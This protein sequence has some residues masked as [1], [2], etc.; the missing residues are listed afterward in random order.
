MAE[1][2][3][4]QPE[5]QDDGIANEYGYFFGRSLKRDKLIKRAAHIISVGITWFTVSAFIEQTIDSFGMNVNAFTALVVKVVAFMIATAIEYGYTDQWHLFARSIVRNKVKGEYLNMFVVN[6]LKLIFFTA[7]NPLTIYIGS[8]NVAESITPD[9]NGYNSQQLIA[10]FEDRKSEKDSLGEVWIEGVK[11]EVSLSKDNVRKKYRS[12]IEAANTEYLRWDTLEKIRN[13]KYVSL[14]A[15]ALKKANDL[16]AEKEEE[17]LSLGDQQANRI[18]EIRASVKAEKIRLD[19]M[20]AK[21]DG[22]N[23]EQ[24][25]DDKMKH[26]IGATTIKS[27]V[28]LFGSFS[29]V[30]VIFFS[31]QEE[32]YY[33][34]TEQEVYS[35]IM[36]PDDKSHSRVISS[37]KQHVDIRAYNLASMLES[38]LPDKKD[39]QYYSENGIFKMPA[40][41]RGM[42]KS[43]HTRRHEETMEH[44]KKLKKQ[45]EKE[46]QHSSMADEIKALRAQIEEL[47]RSNGVSDESAAELRREPGSRRKKRTPSRPSSSVNID[48]GAIRYEEDKEETISG[49]RV[50]FK[51][52]RA[53]FQHERRDGLVLKDEEYCRSSWGSY[54]NKL[55]KTREKLNEASKIKDKSVRDRKIASLEKT[56]SNQ[57]EKQAYWKRA[58]DVLNEVNKQ[59]EI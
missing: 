15:K 36:E 6:V 42:L 40:L 21:I 14:K 55:N 47:R 39:S 1:S 53:M 31:W 18:A 54:T 19:S 11:D 34:K 43:R 16:E 57:L 46:Q 8:V 58:Y 3:T 48:M 9:Y 10:E 28:L 2:T 41:N 20:F 24:D 12:L 13:K 26:N 49:V 50:V 7:L 17:L 44:A 22:Q 25:S 5:A 32:L 51:S 29:W 52:G 37:L 33:H 4:T 45:L 23:I 35:E 59:L 38:T 56:R 30:V 27:I